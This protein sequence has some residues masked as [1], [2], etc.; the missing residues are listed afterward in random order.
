[1]RRSEGEERRRRGAGRRKEE[2]ERSGM[3]CKGG[4]GKDHIRLNHTAKKVNESDLITTVAHNSSGF[5]VSPFSNHCTH[6]PDV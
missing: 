4:G 5:S 1:M 3:G 2:G 6:L